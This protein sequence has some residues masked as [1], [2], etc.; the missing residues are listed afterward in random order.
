MTYSSDNASVA[1][2]DP[3]TGKVTLG[4]V[5]GTAT[6]TATA[7]ASSSYKEAVATYTIELKEEPVA[8]VYTIE[9]GPRSNSQ[10]VSNYTTSWSVTCNSFTCNMVNWNNNRNGWTYVKAGRKSDPSVATITTANPISEEI[11]TVAVTIDA[12]TADKINTLRLYMSS[13]ADFEGAKFYDIEKSAREVVITIDSPAKNMYYKIEADCVADGKNNGI[14]QV[15][16]IVFSS[17]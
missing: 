3:S 10:S 14:I 12:I 16:K 6:I 4:S 1:S 15:S 2:V 9:F 11:K 17:K 13:S 7:A 5:A 8:G